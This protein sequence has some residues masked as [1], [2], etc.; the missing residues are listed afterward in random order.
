[1]KLCKEESIPKL[2]KCQALFKNHL[3]VAQNLWGPKTTRNSVHGQAG[4]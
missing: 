3:L 1:M 4:S 2:D